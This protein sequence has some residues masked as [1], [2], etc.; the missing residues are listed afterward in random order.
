MFQFYREVIVMFCGPHENGQISYRR[1]DAAIDAAL[2]LNLPLVLAG[3]GNFGHDIKMF[4]ER[5]HNMGVHPIESLYD[6][7]ATTLSDAR[8]LC[9][10]LRDNEAFQRVEKIHLVTDYWHMPRASLMLATLLLLHRTSH[11]FCISFISVQTPRPSEL[12]LHY[13]RKGIHDFVNGRYGK[14]KPLI[15]F[16]KPVHPT[17]VDFVYSCEDSSSN[18]T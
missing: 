11:A 14:N 13:E 1:I 15:Q 6:Q 16:G 8:L 17:S 18:N 10:F 5:A 12:V 9:Q 3:D 2:R 7:Q 4:A